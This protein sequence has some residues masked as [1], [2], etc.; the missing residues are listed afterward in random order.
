MVGK[1]ENSSGLWMNK[2]TV[3]IRIASANDV[4]NPISSTQ[5]GI[6]RIIMTITAI[7][8]SANRIVG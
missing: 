8:A 4:A 2:V 7:S 3:N 6:G 5:A 1:A